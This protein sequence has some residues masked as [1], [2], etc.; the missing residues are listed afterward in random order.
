MTLK[1]RIFLESKVWAAEI[2]SLDRDYFGNLD[3]LHTPDILW[4][5]SSDSLIH[6][7]EVINADPGEVL[8]YRNIGNQVRQDDISLMALLEDAVVTSGIQYIVICGYSHCTGIR[9]V[10]L[11]A[12]D[13]PLVSEWLKN[14]TAI[15]EANREELD[16]LDFQQ[17]ERKLAELNI[18]AQIRNL[19]K[20][21]CIQRAWEKND[22]PK[23]YGWYFDLDRGSLRE[24]FSMEEN[25]RLQK[26]ASLA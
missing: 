14:L 7:N 6:V 11:G 8:I 17:R 18:E 2:K 21:P 26:V 9:D 12:E 22:F 13:R 3:G 4:I 16:R 5:G 23:L 10:L 24:V 19:S 20:I 15:Y 1:D 25:H